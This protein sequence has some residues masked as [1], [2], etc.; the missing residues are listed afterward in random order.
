MSAYVSVEKKLRDLATA[1]TTMQADFGSDP[2]TFRWYDR[3]LLQNEIG[4]LLTAGACARVR[5]ISTIRTQNQSGISYLTWPRIQIDI[6]D[7][8]AEQARVVAN[9]VIEFIRGVDLTNPGAYA[10]PVTGPRQS[11]AVLL[12]Q[13]ADVIVGPQSPGG[14]VYFERLEF[15]IANS[16]VLN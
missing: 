3:Q 13:T 5:R 8:V 2:T 4:K 9:D 12:N 1:N 10:S 7:R 16:E 11:A 14:P 6:L 15:R